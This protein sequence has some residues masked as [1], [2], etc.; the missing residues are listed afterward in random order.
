M[1]IKNSLLKYFRLAHDF[2]FSYTVRLLWYKAVVKSE[3][4]ATSLIEKR[5][6]RDYERYLHPQGEKF[7]YPSSEKPY[8]WCMWWQG[9]GFMPDAVRVCYES[10]KKYISTGEVQYVLITKDNYNLYVDIPQYIVDKL[11]QGLI[12]LTH[13]S[14][15]IRIF[16]LEK[17]GGLWVD[18]TLLFTKPINNNYFS[19][20][21]FS[22]N[23]NKTKYH[24]HGYGQKL[25]GCR[26]VGFCL[27]V[28]CA[29]SAIFQYLKYSIMEYWKVHDVLIDYFIM[30][31]LILMAYN[32][33]D[34]YKNL[35]DNVPT[36]NVNLYRLLPRLNDAFDINDYRSIMKDTEMFKISYKCKLEPQIRDKETIWGYIIKHI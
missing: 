21:F 1:I 20:P 3:D 2:G 10:Q 31:R 9:E 36:S 24:P 8:V 12:T 18:S 34:F 7:E 16:L 35:I 29:H 15:I 13:F 19:Q 28:S 5:L 22:V 6:Y 4:K 23:L 14:D 30:N 33:D 27:G 17:W 11:N 25:T 26:W 32:N